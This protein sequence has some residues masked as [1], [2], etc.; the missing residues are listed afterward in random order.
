M[1]NYFQNIVPFFEEPKELPPDRVD[2][3][4]IQPV[5]DSKIPPWRP[6]PQL[7]AFELDRLKEFLRTIL[8]RGFITHSKSPFGV[9]VLFA[10]KKDGSL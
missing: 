4:K 10:K 6:I 7:T 3:M 1:K 9:C 8:E 5:E 2:N